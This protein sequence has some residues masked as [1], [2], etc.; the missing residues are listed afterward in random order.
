M[1]TRLALALLIT[2]ALC[3]G[4]CGGDDPSTAPSPEPEG[5]GAAEPTKAALVAVLRDV[6]QAL[7]AGDA[8]AAVPHFILPEGMSAEKA[9]A[10]VGG[11][12]EKREI[13]GAGIDRLEKDGRY[14]T[15]KEVFAERGE[16]WAERA[17]ADLGKCYALS[18]D[19]AE[20]AALWDGKAF[21]L[22]RLDDVGKL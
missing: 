8:D 12:L 16:S 19:G 15:L 21:K 7:E 11:F 6:L 9:R 2:T 14:G 17:G 18:L 3:F 20:V 22:I 13:S 4:A 1:T 5:A 10:G